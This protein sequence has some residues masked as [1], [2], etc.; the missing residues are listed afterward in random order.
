MKEQHDSQRPRDCDQLTVKCTSGI[1]R[2]K[3]KVLN[4]KLQAPKEMFLLTDALAQHG[5][6][7]S[8]EEYVSARLKSS[9]SEYL[10]RASEVV[11]KASE[12][13]RNTR[14]QGSK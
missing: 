4:V 14:L 11:A 1:N 3:T 13:G 6:F 7:P 10:E 2:H 9:V 5:S 8:I 12:L